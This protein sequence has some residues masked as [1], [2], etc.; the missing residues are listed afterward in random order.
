MRTF[1][2]GLSLIVGLFMLMF[3]NEVN[4]Q[5]TRHIG[6]ITGAFGSSI[7]FREIVGQGSPRVEILI[8][9]KHSMRN[10]SHAYDHRTWPQFVSMFQKALQAFHSI[11]PGERE[12]L[13]PVSGI[14]MI[15]DGAHIFIAS[16]SS[17]ALVMLI[18]P[19]VAQF[20]L[21]IERVDEQF[22]PKR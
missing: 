14:S 7:E 17:G 1:Q 4:G 22:K 10:G 21:L 2:I 16:A 18:Q 12:T 9:D 15:I 5:R 3:A 8:S 19:E 20:K 13:K 6:N 11:G